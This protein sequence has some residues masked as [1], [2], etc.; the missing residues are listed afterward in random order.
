MQSRVIDI[1]SACSVWRGKLIQ[2]IEEQDVPLAS[3]A[4]LALNNLLDPSN[5]LVFEN[6]GYFRETEGTKM[7]I[8]PNCDEK[9]EYENNV[10]KQSGYHRF[11]GQR[12]IS[13]YLYCSNKKCGQRITVNSVNDLIIDRDIV[14]QRKFLPEKPTVTNSYSQA[15][16]SSQY[17]TWASICASELEKAH[18]LQRIEVSE[19]DD[20]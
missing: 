4:V 9:T 15:V 2:A 1:N 3:L 16:N 13:N 18:A 14:S 6:D 17:W 5:R 11:S 7:A 19:R 20:Y 10:K 8:C 12:W